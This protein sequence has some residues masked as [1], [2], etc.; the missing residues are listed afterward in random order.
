MINF[1]PGS[2]MYIIHV[3][4]AGLKSDQSGV[5]PPQSYL[6]PHIRCNWRYVSP[7]FNFVEQRLRRCGT[8]IQLC[9]AGQYTI[10]VYSMISSVLQFTMY[11]IKAPISWAGQY[12]QYNFK[13]TSVYSV[14][15]KSSNL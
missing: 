11:W 8:V 13:C 14:L 6:S 12:V 7:L 15:D 1:R 5:S 3:R 4:W 9:W 10:I 2:L